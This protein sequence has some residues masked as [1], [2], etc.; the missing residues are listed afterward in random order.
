MAVTLPS[1]LHAKPRQANAPTEAD[2][3]GLKRNICQQISH[4]QPLS[5]ETL[6]SARG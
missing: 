3:A 1:R 6:A 5:P 2:D 4:F